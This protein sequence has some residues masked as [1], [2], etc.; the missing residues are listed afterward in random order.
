MS[1]AQLIDPGLLFGRPLG[2]TLNFRLDN[3]IGTKYANSPYYKGTKLWN[4]LSKEIQDS[5]SI[6]LYKKEIG[7]VYSKFVKNFYV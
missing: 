4:T 3:K 1:L 6:Y 2:L 7:K 5:E